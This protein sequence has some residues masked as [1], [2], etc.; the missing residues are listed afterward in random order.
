MASLADTRQE[1]AEALDATGAATVYR[2]RKLDPQSPAFVVGWP[3]SMVVSAAMGSGIR[4][5]VV[6]VNIGVQ[7]DDDEG[8]DAA[9]EELIEVAVAAVL[10][11]S[12]WSVQP[13]V[14]FGEEIT[15]D[16]RVFIWCRLPVSVLA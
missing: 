5:Y 6:D 11:G 1:L 8:A 2:R 13:V 3:Q 10:A 7:V 9:L 4:E 16:G 14:D 12:S 15:A